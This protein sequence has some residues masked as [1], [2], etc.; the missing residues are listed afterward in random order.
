MMN[1][2][3]APGG[4]LIRA[5]EIAYEPEKNT[6][7]LKYGFLTLDL[8]L[9]DQTWAHKTVLCAHGFDEENEELWQVVEYKYWTGID[10]I[11]L[12]YECV[13]LAE[14]WHWYTVGIES[15]AYQAS[16]Q[17]VYRHL[18][19]MENYDLF[20]FVP[21]PAVRK[22]VHR[23]ATWAALLK[24]VMPSADKPEVRAQYAL[25][26]GDFLATQQL[27]TFNPTKKDND[28]DIID[29]CAHGVTMIS[30]YLPQIMRQ[31]RPELAGSCK[32][33]YQIA[34]V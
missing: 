4:G 33:I 13:A 16:L 19:L 29:A 24:R 17:H 9:S 14:K 32:S 6:G 28:D 34:A 8:A 1:L 12:F 31:I 25:T 30:I 11:R 15:V 20:S 2:P 26:Q 22:K 18:A 7:D 23:L 5:D 3:M 27:L 10:P 21:L